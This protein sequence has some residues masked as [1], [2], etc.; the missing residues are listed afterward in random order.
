MSVRSNQ[1]IT[2]CKPLGPDSSSVLI[3][4]YGSSQFQIIEDLNQ[5]V[6]VV[7]EF[8]DFMLELSSPVSVLDNSCLFR[9]KKFNQSVSITV[10]LLLELIDIQLGFSLFPSLNIAAQ[11]TKYILSACGHSSR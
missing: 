2:I 11:M 3:V 8:L 10:V 7:P 1:W 5:L 4:G 6:K 9:L